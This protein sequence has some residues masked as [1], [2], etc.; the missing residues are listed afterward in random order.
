MKIVNL[1][2]N[3]RVYTSNVFLVL[4][5]WN[6]LD[7]VNTL[8]DV[9]CDEG[10]IQKIE[11]INTGL[12]K[13]KIDQVILTHSHSDHTG[14]LSK[15]IEVFK[16]EIYAFNSNLSGTNQMLKDGDIIKIGERQFEVFHITAH[17]Y[18]SICLFNETDEI[19]FAGDTV[20]PIEF[21]NTALEEENADVLSRLCEKKIKSVYY[22]H[23]PKQ[24]FSANKFQ[25]MKGK[26]GH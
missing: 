17:S 6:S 5:E 8:I 14:L 16:P 21:E 18:D 25:F 26:K 2:E 10:I 22:G 15:I 24:N 7:D 12:G 3:S 1:T 4:G 9:G 20:F 11:N 19:L 23:G 13:Q